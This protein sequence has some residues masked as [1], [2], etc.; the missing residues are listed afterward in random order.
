MNGKTAKLINRH[1][2]SKCRVYDE[3]YRCWDNDPIMIIPNEP[4]VKQGRVIQW[5]TGLVDINN[6][7]IYEGDIVRVPS[8]NI[9]ANLFE[10]PKY[11]CGVVKWVRESFC[12]NEKNIGSTNISNYAFCDCCSSNLEI[13]GNIFDTPSL[14]TEN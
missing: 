7:E 9:T 3:K 13:I 11:I 4:I 14:E 5:W 8:S 6:K 12:I 10:M 2:I 1:T